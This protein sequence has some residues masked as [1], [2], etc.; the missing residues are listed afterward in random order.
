MTR[1]SSGP[2]ALRIRALR[3]ASGMGGWDIALDWDK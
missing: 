2:I 3:P 1:P